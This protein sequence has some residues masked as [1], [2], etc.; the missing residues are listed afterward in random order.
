MITFSCTTC[1]AP[2]PLSLDQDGFECGACHASGPLPGTVAEQVLAARR[3]LGSVDVSNRQLAATQQRALRWSGLFQGCFGVLLALFVLGFLVTAGLITWLVLADGSVPSA[4]LVAW[5]VVPSFLPLLLILVPGLLYLFVLRRR[6][7][8][9]EAA[10][11]AEPP[12]RPGEAAR[13]HVCGG[14]LAASGAAAVA[15]CGYCQADNLVSDRALAR[16]A[17]ARVTDL[18][19]L[20]QR[21]ASE[22]GGAGVASIGGV[23]LLPVLSVAAPVASVVLWIGAIA[24]AA[25]LEGPVD[26]SVRLAWVDSK[27]GRCVAQL[28]AATHRFTN[29][30]LDDLVQPDPAT[31]FDATALVGQHVRT[32]DA[33]SHAA[34]HGVITRVYSSPLLPDTVY[35]AVDSGGDEDVREVNAGVCQ[36]AASK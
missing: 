5:L 33:F 28:D 36:E 6:R 19:K 13:C 11:A 21:V 16:A 26:R 8:T 1:G 35:I 31:A 34:R 2:L 17:R 10:C 18:S 32:I 23:L 9:L 12:A 29:S 3:V 25:H 27:Q 7:R 20:E 4:G 24:S 14:A 22:A 30:G 15:R